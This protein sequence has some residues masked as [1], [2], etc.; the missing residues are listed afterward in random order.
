MGADPTEEGGRAQR[1]EV[2][3]AAE[4]DSD[5]GLTLGD[6]YTSGL[7]LLNAIAVLHEERFLAKHG[8]STHSPEV[9][10]N[11]GS[12]KSKVLSIVK[13]VRLVMTWPLIALNIL[14]ILFKLLLG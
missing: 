2:G 8:W 11:P 5:M 4:H 1:V 14:T 10:L 13:A 3:A 9:T 6:L 12:L 7:L